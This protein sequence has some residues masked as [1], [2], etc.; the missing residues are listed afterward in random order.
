MKTSKLLL[1]N[2]KNKNNLI[3][4]IKFQNKFKF[5][6]STN[7]QFLNLT[8]DKNFEYYE[9]IA[10]EGK[11][12]EV[13][14][15]VVNARKSGDLTIKNVWK[16]IRGYALLKR[17]EEA[18]QLYE[19]FLEKLESNDILGEIHLHNALLNVYILT[20]NSDKA[21]EVFQK[22]PKLP[23]KEMDALLEKET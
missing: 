7:K 23:K 4:K 20:K 18:E 21:S 8:N 11:I 3:K 5:Y 14:E 19:E 2:N 16:Y 9:K 17:E 6:H 1:S 13:N 22:I 15:A 12:E 10:S